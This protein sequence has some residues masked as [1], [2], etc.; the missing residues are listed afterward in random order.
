MRWSHAGYLSEHLPAELRATAIGSAITLSGVGSTV[1]AWS[2]GSLWDPDVAGFQSSKPFVAAAVLGLV[3]SVALLVFDRLAPIRQ[4]LFTK[5]K[6]EAMAHPVAE[7]SQ[8]L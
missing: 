3:G 1:Y 5:H 8:D 6:D 4:T 7:V 2:A